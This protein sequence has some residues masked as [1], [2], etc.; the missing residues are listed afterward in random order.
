MNEEGFEYIFSGIIEFEDFVTQI[1]FEKYKEVYLISSKK[2]S[3]RSYI[4]P[5][6]T[7]DSDYQQLKRILSFQIITKRIK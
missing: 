6:E 2:S 5:G 7:F 3:L 4:Q 1:L